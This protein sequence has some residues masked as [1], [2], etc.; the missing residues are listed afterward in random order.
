MRHVL[1]H[2]QYENSVR[3]CDALDPFAKSYASLVIILK[4]T[5]R[6]VADYRRN[7]RYCYEKQASMIYRVRQMP[8]AYRDFYALVDA[9][10]PSHV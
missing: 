6:A 4:A 10:L 8:D 7:I 2:V 5:Q 9:R 1:S 3:E